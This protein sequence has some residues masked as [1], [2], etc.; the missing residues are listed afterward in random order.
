MPQKLRIQFLEG[1]D[2]A[3]PSHNPPTVRARAAREDKNAL[4]CSP[5]NSQRPSC[6]IGSSCYRY[7]ASLPK[8]SC[9]SVKTAI[10]LTCDPEIFDFY[11]RGLPSHVSTQWRPFGQT[12]SLFLAA[13]S[14]AQLRANGLKTFVLSSSAQYR[15]SA[16]DR[17]L[18]VFRCV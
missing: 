10:L 7:N 1:V 18:H 15:K 6:T 11:V 14:R 12:A 3:A 17:R 4:S 8:H 16:R 9:F 13:A 2:G 5:W